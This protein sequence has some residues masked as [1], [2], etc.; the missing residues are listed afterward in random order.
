MRLGALAAALGA[1]TLF[2]STA[3]HAQQESPECDRACLRKALDA[4]LEAV[5][6]HNPAAARLSDDHYATQNTAAVRS[7]ESF[8]KD[9]SGYGSLQRRYF[10]PVNG[11]AAYL[12]LL[13]RQGVE[14]VSS[15]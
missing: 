9:I 11:A 6:K 2:G 3:V 10:D 1:C 8:W 7:G 12:G 5:F 15:V 4:Y 13:R 14:V